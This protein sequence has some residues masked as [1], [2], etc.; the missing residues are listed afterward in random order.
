[1]SLTV[2]EKNS[3]VDEDGGENYSIESGIRAEAQP[4]VDSILEYHREA[5]LYDVD[6]NGLPKGLNWD[7][8]YDRQHVR[9]K[10]D[11]P[12]DH[13]GILPGFG[14]DG[15]GE[16]CYDDCG[17]AHPFVCDSCGHSVE[18]G[19][20][21]ARSVCSRC[22]V[23]W[24][25]DTGINKSAKVRRVR[26]EKHRHTADREH[27]K[28]HHL[29]ASP[30]LDW[31]YDLASMGYS[32]E[33]ANEIT[34]QILKKALDEM[35]APGVVIRHDYR[36]KHPDGSIRSESDDQGF[37]KTVLNSDRDFFGDVRDALAWRPHYHCIV[38]SDW[39]KG[40][41]FTT[42]IEN[43][44]GWIFHRIAREDTGVS[45]QSD[46][47]MAA[48]LTYSGSHLSIDVGENRNTSAISEVGSFE[49]DGI[50]N[51]KR[52]SARPSDLTWADNKVSSLSQEILGMESATTECGVELPGVD[53]PDELARRILEE[54]YPDDDDRHNVDTDAVLHHVDQGHIQVDVSTTS[55]S[56]GSITV[57]DAF[58]E[59]VG[60]G[61][62]ASSASD[63]PD[64]PST[65]IAYDGGDQATAPIADQEASDQGASSDDQDD[66]CSCCGSLIPLG[67]FRDRRLLER[68]DWVA[69]AP[70]ADEAREV[71]REW[72]D[73]LLRWRSEPP[74]DSIGV[75]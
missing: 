75:D 9:D 50:A 20:T 5:G 43:Q 54:L 18:F 38:V 47:K 42:Y 13:E 10:F 35:R 17:D 1:M 8:E 41:D 57:K 55:G 44:T 63:I 60:P 65:A 25:R 23:A 7:D 39:I 64:A 56:G 21:C 3:I 61:G 58:G 70:H 49:G 14:P 28:I 27:Q 12:D 66:D 45:L 52:F 51:S 15:Y 62:F 73:D 59:P 16:T 33:E 19:R 22:G 72:D 24:I 30:S 37:W 53:E 34:K 32:L 36:G 48:A 40:G 74:G 26:K 6:E 11:N 2:E 4:I 69:D 46:G 68:D 67:E 31:Y 71:D 29:I